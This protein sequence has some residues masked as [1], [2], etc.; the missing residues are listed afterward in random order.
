MPPKSST[1]NVRIIKIKRQGTTYMMEVPLKSTFLDLKNTLMLMVNGTGGLKIDDKP[2]PLSDQDEILAR[3]MSDN[4]IKVPDIGLVDDSDSDTDLENGKNDTEINS[5]TNSNNI[6]ITVN[7]IHL[8][9]FTDNHDIYNCEIND[10]AVSDS[11][12][13][14]NLNFQDFVS[15]AFRYDNEP[16]IIYE[17]KYV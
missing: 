2:I 9:S 1:P 7:N 10:M 5:N 17:P 14:E 6:Q 16:Y 3:G 12:K 15:L 13:I 4:S 11:T 8:G